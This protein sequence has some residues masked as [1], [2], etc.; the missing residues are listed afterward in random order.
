[1]KKCLKTKSNINP[2]LSKFTQRPATTTI[3][4][5]KKNKHYTVTPLFQNVSIATLFFTY[6]FSRISIY[7]FFLKNILTKSIIIVVM[8]LII[9]KTSTN[10]GLSF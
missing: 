10:M 1:M 4:H 5:P 8:G 7:C 2:E 9:F 3:S 6:I